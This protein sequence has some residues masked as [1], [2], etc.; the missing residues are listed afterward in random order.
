M[1]GKY[2]GLMSLSLDRE[3]TPGQ[4]RELR[5]HLACCAECAFTWDRWRML[6]RRLTH[7][8]LLA[9]A[10]GF[11]ERVLARLQERRQRRSWQKWLGS[12]LVLVW[13]A[14]FCGFWMAVAGLIWWGV[15]HPL[16]GALVLS[17][18]ARLISGVS[19]LLRGLGAVIGSVPPDTLALG[20]GLSACVT[21]C[22]GAL[23]LWVV[24]RSR[25]WVGATA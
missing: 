15:R 18:A 20:V 6:D 24:G 12:G 17:T 10:P 16:E 19:W 21:V 3:T 7:V 5:E 23:W 14:L 22:L 4:E 2:T 13:G 8:P 1:H 25:S 11:T 9:P